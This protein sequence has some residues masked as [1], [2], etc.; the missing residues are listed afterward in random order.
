MITP[1][2]SQHE[3]R[4]LA[5]LAFKEILFS[6]LQWVGMAESGDLNDKD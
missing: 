6:S 1:A 3:A 5:S 2:T 4:A